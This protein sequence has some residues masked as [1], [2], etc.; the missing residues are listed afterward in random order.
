MECL[1]GGSS[2]LI[3]QATNIVGNKKFK[4]FVFD[5]FEGLSEP[6][7]EDKPKFERIFKWK[8]N[9]LKC[10]INTTKRNLRK[11]N[12]IYYYKG[13]IPDQ[14]YNIQYEKLA[15]VHIDVDLYKPTYDCL[16]FFYSRMVQGG[17]IICDDYG[18]ESCPGANKA[19]ID[20]MK[21]KPEK[22]IH[23]TTGQ[24]LIIKI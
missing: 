6:S 9:D 22:I 15:L 5:S 13:W 21:D 23:L 8:R 12:N 2:F 24:G 19:F 1:R 11:F 18:F 16:E 4:H 10:S 17:M 20:F 3:C 14:F 7:D